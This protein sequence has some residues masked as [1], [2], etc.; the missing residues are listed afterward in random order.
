MHTV[1]M[2]HSIC[3]IAASTKNSDSKPWCPEY[4]S[5]HRL[6]F[7]AKNLHF[8]LHGILL[9]HSQMWMKR[10]RT[11]KK[12]NHKVQNETGMI[13][14]TIARAI[15]MIIIM[16]VYVLSAREGIRDIRMPLKTN[17]IRT[18]GGRIVASCLERQICAKS[19]TPH[20][21]LCVRFFL[22]LFLP[23]KTLPW[24]MA[25]SLHTND[26]KTPNFYRFLVN[27]FIGCRS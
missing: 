3:S 12:Q 9:N 11:K 22:L 25:L 17:G 20:K 1:S 15:F 23:F 24:I 13:E 27:S 6:S 5:K 26:G 4:K 8:M 2:P 7:Q 19:V 16:I 10:R 14:E 21:K 18:S